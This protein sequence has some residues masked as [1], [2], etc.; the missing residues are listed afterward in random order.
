MFARDYRAWA[1]EALRG[2][3]AV[4]IALCLV[5]GLLGGGVD[6]V[7]GLF[8]PAAGQEAAQL[9]EMM[10]LIG[11]GAWPMMLTITLTSILL[12]FVLSGALSLGMAHYFTNLTSHRPAA[13]RDLFARF[14]LLGKALWMN[15]VT[16]FYVFL[17]SM[18][19]VIPATAAAVVLTMGDLYGMASVALVIILIGTF[20]GIIATYRY[21]MIPYLIAEFPDLTVR[22]AMDESKRLMQGNKWRLF[23]LQL[24]FLGWVLLIL[25]VTMGMGSFV[26]TPYTQAAN[27]AFYLD[28]TGRKGLRYAEPM[29]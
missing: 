13:F 23:C 27:A 26:L 16:A 6:L 12:A 18:V 3:W 15:I 17:W 24:S 5:A 11:S 28:V 7:S 19:G 4:A 21:A 20:P 14:N 8:M 1:R 9:P 25:F 10:E 2:H 22:E 29:Q